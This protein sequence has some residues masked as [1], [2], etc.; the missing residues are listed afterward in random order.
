M[1]SQYFKTHA[2]GK[3]KQIHSKINKKKSIHI[4]RNHSAKNVAIVFAPKFSVWKSKNQS[5]VIVEWDT[6]TS[7]RIGW[8]SNLI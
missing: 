1:N 4:W 3:W 6:G 7:S 8:D 5:K 2:V